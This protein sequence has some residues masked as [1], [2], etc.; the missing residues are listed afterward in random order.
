MPMLRVEVAE[1]LKSKI[2]EVVLPSVVQ[3]ACE[4]IDVW[5]WSPQGLQS[6][7][8]TIEVKG[9]LIRREVAGRS[10]GRRRCRA[11]RTQWD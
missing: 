6:T 7:A 11:Q 4:K 2:R 8:E 9:R 3:V 10:A 5:W 1:A